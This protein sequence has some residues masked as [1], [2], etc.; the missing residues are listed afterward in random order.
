[1]TRFL[2]SVTEEMHEDLKTA[3]RQHGCTLCGLIRDILWQWLERRNSPSADG[4]GG[5]LDG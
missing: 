2:L 3:A 4:Q 5:K 1:M